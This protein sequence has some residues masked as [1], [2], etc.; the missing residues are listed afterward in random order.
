MDG[1]DGNCW[2]KIMLGFCEYGEKHSHPKMT[3]HNL[4]TKL[5]PTERSVAGRELVSK[6]RLGF[7]GCEI[8]VGVL[9][10]IFAVEYC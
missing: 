2:D 1:G 3:S 9:V 7:V 5:M 10:G 6:C 8:W 4:L